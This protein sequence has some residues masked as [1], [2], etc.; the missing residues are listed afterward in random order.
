MNVKDIFDKNKLAIQ[1]ESYTCGPVAL[2]NILHMKN[3]FSYNEEELARLCDARVGYGTTPEN[4][5]KAAQKLGLEVVEEK[6]N[7]NVEDIQRNIDMG[8]YVII[9]YKNAFSGNSHYT[10]VTK[11]DDKAL[12]CRDSAFG[13]LRFSKEYLEKF[14]HGVTHDASRNSKQWFM[15]LK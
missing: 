5:V 8:A 6:S 7:G 10:V 14:W 15:A 9:L 13:L 3:D 12:Y 1:Q 11:Y 4:L 2:L